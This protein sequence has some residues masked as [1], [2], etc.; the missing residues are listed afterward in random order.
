MEEKTIEGSR[1]KKHYISKV[2]SV[3]LS[4]LF[5]VLTVLFLF[6][7]ISGS[8]LAKWYKET[9]QTSFREIF[10]THKLGIDGADASFLWGALDAIK[11]TLVLAIIVLGVI[12]AA[13]I[14]LHRKSR[15]ETGEH[16][17]RRAAMFRGAVVIVL[18]LASIPNIM[19]ATKLLSIDDFIKMTLMYTDIYDK[20]YVDP[21]SVKITHEGKKRNLLLIYM[22]SMESSYA[23]REYGGY[24]KTADLIPKLRK[25]AGENVS[26]ADRRGNELR[27]LHNTVG[28][29][30]TTGALFGTTSGVPFSFLTGKNTLGNDGEKFASGIFTM[31]DFLEK[32]GYYQEFLCGSDAVFGGRAA[33]FSEH[34]KYNIFDYYTA[35]DKK[36]IDPNYKV[37]WG[38]E[39]HKLYEIAKDELTRVSKQEE[40]FNLTML[41][42]DTHHVGGYRCKWCGNKY[43]KNLSNVVS[44]AD[45]QIYDFIRW[46][47]KQ[48]WY[49]NT[50]IVIMG[51]HRRM[52]KQLVSK[53]PDFDRCVYNCFINS[54]HDD[55]KVD[56]TRLAATI[57]AFPTILSSIGY[58]TKGHRLGLGTD[59]FSKRKTLAEEM[60]FEKLNDEL[61]KNSHYYQDNFQ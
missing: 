33:L 1:S 23:S 51:D 60:T 61:G 9:F 37:W 55:D 6:L 19:Y 28:T 46:C 25:L 56:Q 54:V 40:P 24:M 4:V 52:D 38:F 41:T 57:D 50:T 48:D 30:W 39:D 13:D 45:D 43:K 17:D 16:T 34:G 27:G 20:E 32:E 35:I 36:Y 53:L 8:S 12:I 26:F 42:V 3:I 15:E 49:E 10:F 58:E 5:Y 47:E 22:E 21:Q 14:Y 7:T 31:G 59:L 11:W 18:M 44:C 29:T 2:L